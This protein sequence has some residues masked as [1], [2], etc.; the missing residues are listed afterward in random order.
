MDYRPADEPN[1]R[2]RNGILEI[3]GTP[4]RAKFVFDVEVWMACIHNKG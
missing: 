3:I 4:G 1:V 2:V